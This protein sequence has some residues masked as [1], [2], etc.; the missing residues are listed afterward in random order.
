MTYEIESPHDIESSLPPCVAC[1]GTGTAPRIT[2]DPNKRR[3]VWAVEEIPC[4]LC[5]AGERDEDG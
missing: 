1:D 5:P 3:G 4:P 2:P